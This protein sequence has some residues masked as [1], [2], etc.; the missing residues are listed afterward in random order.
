MRPGV[1][2]SR[3][4]VA[5]LDGADVHL[6]AAEVAA[7]GD[8]GQVRVGLVGAAEVP[9]ALDRGVLEHGDGGADWPDEARR[10]Q[11]RLD[12]LGARLAEVRSERV[13][14]L[15]LVKPV[16]AADQ[17]EDEAPPLDH[18]GYRL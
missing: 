2:A 16:V 18:Y 12:L 15:H 1:G 4:A 9:V 17:G 11:L 3:G 8:P 5:G 6:L 7:R 13:A 10:P 14:Q